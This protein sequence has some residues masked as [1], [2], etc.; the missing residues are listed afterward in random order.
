MRR[1]CERACVARMRAGARAHGRT[2]AERTAPSGF[3][4]ELFRTWRSLHGREGCFLGPE[5]LT[6]QM[7]QRSRRRA[8]HGAVVL[9]GRFLP[10]GCVAHATQPIH[11]PP[12]MLRSGVRA[13]ARRTRAAGGNTRKNAPGRTRPDSYRPAEGPYESARTKAP[14]K[15]N[16]WNAEP[17]ERL[18]AT[19]TGDQ[20]RVGLQKRAVRRM[21]ILPPAE[22]PLFGASGRRSDRCAASMRCLDALPRCAASM[23]CLGALPRG[24]ASGRC[25]GALP[26]ALP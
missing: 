11:E 15:T 22:R 17:E 3:N 21:E 4:N 14:R 19:L 8:G 1:G 24:A 6:F 20:R 18:S 12:S 2:G 25:L 23:R 9:R 10:I 26:R 5:G 7:C 16:Q 13:S